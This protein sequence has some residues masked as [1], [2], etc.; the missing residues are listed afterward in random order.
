MTQLPIS[1]Y[2]WREPKNFPDRLMLNYLWRERKTDYFIFGYGQ[3][4]PW[5][6]GNPN[7]VS[8]LQDPKDYDLVLHATRPPEKWLQYGCLPNNALLPVVNT[9]VLSLLSQLCPHD[10]QAFP[11]VIQNENPKIPDFENHDYHLLNITQCV[12]A[13]DAERT[14]FSR[15]SDELGGNPIG[16]RGHLCFREGCLGIHHLARDSTLHSHLLASPEL[17]ALFKK[18]KVKGVRFMKEEEYY[19]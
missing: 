18:E 2:L 1:A 13:I 6:S 5:D 12:G 17:V 19:H 10:F 8:T 3:P 11:V 7:L 4:L 16:I 15:L 14:E 9:R